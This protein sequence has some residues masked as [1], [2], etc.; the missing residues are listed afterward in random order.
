[1]VLK[2]EKEKSNYLVLFKGDKF[3]ITYKNYSILISL[4]H[5]QPH[6]MI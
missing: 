6:N 3:Y 1:M 2:Q 5:N 4:I